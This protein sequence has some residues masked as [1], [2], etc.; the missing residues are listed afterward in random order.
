MLPLRREGAAA[1]AVSRGVGIL[2]D[3][4]LAHQRLFV[5]ERRAV[6]IQKALGIDEDARAMFLENFVAVAGLGVEAH[7]VGK[8]GAAAAL[9]A[10]AQAALFGRDAVLFEQRADFLRGAL[11]QV[12]RSRLSDWRL[13][14]PC[15]ILQVRYEFTLHERARHAAPLQSSVGRGSTRLVRGLLGYG[16]FDA[17]LLLPVADGGLDGVFGEHGAVNLDRRKRKLAHDVR[18]LDG[19]RFFDRLALDP[20]GGERRA[21]DRRAAAEG[22]ELGFFDDLR[23][24]I[25]LHLQLHHVAALRRADETGADVGIFLRQAADVARIVVVID[26]LIAVCHCCCSLPN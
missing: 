21:G 18:V 7:G 2:E 25:D 6:Q 5:F 20:L 9:H 26:D 1:A 8:T 22:L 11:G 24:G 16:H 3:E 4:A 13:L 14:L 12:N 19:E 15:S 23:V 17:V 10:D